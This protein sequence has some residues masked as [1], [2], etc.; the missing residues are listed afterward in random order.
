MTVALAAALLV[1]LAV[2]AVSLNHVAARLSLIEVALNEGLPPGHEIVGVPETIISPEETAALLGPGIHL[3][4]SRG[5][6]ACMRLID[7][8]AHTALSAPVDLHLRYIDRP[9]PIAETVA[10]RSNARLHAHEGD[11][12]AQVGADPL[13]YTIVIGANQLQARGVSPTQAQVVSLAR[14]AGFHVD[15]AE[16]ADH[17]ATSQP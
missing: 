6:H 11:L 2:L 5:C 1:T 17:R 12:A 8:L 10:A 16:H 4:L 3:F 7:E 13:P 9:R 14:D 15:R